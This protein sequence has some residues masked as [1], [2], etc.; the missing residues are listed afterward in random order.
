MPL[1]SPVQAFKKRAFKSARRLMF[2]LSCNES[3]DPKK[4]A[5]ALDDNT[6]VKSV[7]E[8]GSPPATSTNRK[9]SRPTKPPKSRSQ[10]ISQKMTSSSEK[11]ENTTSSTVSGDSKAGKGAPEEDEAAIQGMEEVVSAETTPRDLEMENN[12]TGLP[13]N[14]LSLQEQQRDREA[15]DIIVAYNTLLQEIAS[16]SSQ[17]PP[18]DKAQ[19]ALNVLATMKCDD[20]EVDPNGRIWRLIDHGEASQPSAATLQVLSGILDDAP[21]E[22]SH[23]VSDLARYNTSLMKIA[24]SELE[25]KAKRAGNLLKAMKEKA[26]EPS[27]ITRSLLAQCSINDFQQGREMKATKSDDELTTTTT[28][29][30][31][32]KKVRFSGMNTTRIIRRRSISATERAFDPLTPPKRVSEPVDLALGRFSSGIRDD[33]PAAPPRRRESMKIDVLL[34][35][36][37]SE[38]SPSDSDGSYT[39]FSESE[40]FRLPFMDETPPQLKVVESRGTGIIRVPSGTMREG[41]DA[42]KVPSRGS[43][44]EMYIS[45]GGDMSSNRP[46]TSRAGGATPEIPRKKETPRKSHFDPDLQRTAAPFRGKYKRRSSISGIERRKVPLFPPRRVASTIDD[47]IDTAMEVLLQVEPAESVAQPTT[48]T[49][50]VFKEPENDGSEKSSRRGGPIKASK[51]HSRRDNKSNILAPL[52]SDSPPWRMIDL[53][54]KV[55]VKPPADKAQAEDAVEPSGNDYSSQL[56]KEKELKESSSSKPSGVELQPTEIEL[57]KEKIER[58]SLSSMDLPSRHQLPMNASSTAPP[59]RRRNSVEA[60]P[61]PPKRRNYEELK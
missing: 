32:G 16:N 53:P 35:D 60:T 43:S 5:V 13:I 11:S 25:D 24:E 56:Q 34:S 6:D 1:S 2:P 44:E 40:L 18:A 54:D 48:D 49:F 17:H 38:G 14:L 19:C 10:S 4:P 26:V 57:L 9:A 31:V 7:P 3:T 27:D 20:E 21:S 28:T 36:R 46:P 51:K 45:E 12:Y 23:A 55:R 59:P 30:I 61:T 39:S 37:R 22:K 50:D 58:H 33:R 41:D 42:P 15:S 8:D 29:G 47:F 52:R